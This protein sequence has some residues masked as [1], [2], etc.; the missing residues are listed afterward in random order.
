[1]EPDVDADM[2]AAYGSTEIGELGM[3]RREGG[4]GFGLGFRRLML[5]T[6]GVLFP[7]EWCNRQTDSSGLF[8]SY[9]VK[10]LS[11]HTTIILIITITLLF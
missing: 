10:S 8:L 7:I 5:Y 2:A 11:L 9:P 3:W 6:G 4:F 1:M